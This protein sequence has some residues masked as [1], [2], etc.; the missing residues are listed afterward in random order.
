MAVKLSRQQALELGRA[1]EIDAHKSAKLTIGARGA[2]QVNSAMFVK[3]HPGSFYCIGFVAGS[4]KEYEPHAWARINGSYVEC[5]PQEGVGHKYILAKELTFQQIIEAVRAVGIDDRVS[6]I[7]P[8]LDGSG[9]FFF[10]I[11]DD[12]A[13]PAE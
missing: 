2:C 1:I 3:N 6:F 8:L 10:S 7:P 5:S 12:D 4:R 11:P 9:K 13:N